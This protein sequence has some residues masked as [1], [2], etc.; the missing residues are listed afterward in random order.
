[1][2]TASSAPDLQL[3]DTDAS[4]TGS[5]PSR[6]RPS[7][8]DLVVLGIIVANVVYRWIISRP[9]Y[10]WQDDYFMMMWAQENP[11]SLDYLLLPA[12]DH[13]QPL[14][15]A[16]LWVA[17]RLF[18]GSYDA[19]FAWTT[20]LYAL[21]LWFLY[22]FLRV[23]FGWRVQLYL[24]LVLAGFSVFTLQA[25]LWYASSVW[26]APLVCGSFLTLWMVARYRDRP[27]RGALALVLVS[28]T[29]TVL[30]H[31]FAVAVPVMVVALVS[32]VPV[33]DDARTGVGA[34]ARSWRLWPVL[35]L[36]FMLVPWFYLRGTDTGTPR[37]FA[38]GTAA[39]FVVREWVSSVAPGTVGGPWTFDAFLGP[40]WALITPYGVFW[41]LQLAALVLVV[42]P[43]LRRRTLRVWLAA[44][45][46]IVAQLTA[47]AVG[48]TFP[49]GVPVVVRYVSPA[50]VPL[51]VALA[52]SLAAAPFDATAWRARA[53]PLRRAWQRLGAVGRG[54]VVVALVQVYALSFSFTLVAP[55]TQNPRSTIREYVEVRLAGAQRL[56]PS[57]ELIP[58]YVA[59]HVIGQ[60]VAPAPGTTQVVLGISPG[61]PRWVSQ[62]TGVLQGFAADGTLVEEF[63]YGARS[64][65]GPNGPCGYAVQGGTRVIPLEGF[66]TYGS[67]TVNMGILGQGEH[68]AT[69]EL[70]LQG[71]VVRSIEVVIPSGLQRLYFP[72]IGVGD[73]LRVTPHDRGRFCVT[74]LVIGERAHRTPSGETVYDS[75]SGEAFDYTLPAPG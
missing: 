23:T 61:T 6:R 69:V 12:S 29:A 58:Q 2:S 73:A 68:P 24:V 26:M 63:V 54:A 25:Y 62:T 45:L 30:S 17:Q 31:P 19:A 38:P 70:L 18:P 13:F 32:A 55:V 4:D 28:M 48:R 56:G 20:A 52:C 46:V 36:P 60:A 39:T 21:S 35:A 67:S 34:L 5:T 47:V 66:T 65:P 40:E 37:D 14:G 59:E 16:L 22:R 72:L 74:D 27:S 41:T 42:L 49:L 57:A 50:V 43:L 51:V 75:P 1:M 64:R 15:L 8:T 44:V 11:L 7:R 33:R 53:E 10:F 71:T 9:G 3:D